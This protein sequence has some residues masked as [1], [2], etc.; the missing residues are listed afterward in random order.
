MTIAYSKKTLGAG[1]IGG[2]GFWL[3]KD[4]LYSINDPVLAQEI[5]GDIG[6][7][8]YLVDQRVLADACVFNAQTPYVGSLY[9]R[10]EFVIDDMDYPAIVTASDTLAAFTGTD[11][12]LF[13][14]IEYV[15]AQILYGRYSPVGLVPYQRHAGNTLLNNI[16]GTS[17][18]DAAT[19]IPIGS[20]G[21]TDTLP[22]LF[23]VSVVTGSI[24]DGDTCQVTISQYSNGFQSWSVYSEEI[25]KHNF[26]N[27]GNTDHPYLRDSDN[28]VTVDISADNHN[29]HVIPGLDLQFNVD[30]VDGSAAVVSVGYEYCNA[31]SEVGEIGD[32][33][34]RTEYYN[35][36]SAYGLVDSTGNVSSSINK[37]MLYK[38]RIYNV[39]GTLQT[40]CQFH[41]RPLVRLDQSNANT[42]F[43]QWFMGPAGDC[44][45]TKNNDDAYA[46]TFSD[47][48]AGSPN[49]ISLHCS[50][51]VDML[52]TEINS[53]TYVPTGTTH[54]DATG[55][56][57][58]GSTLYRW[59]ALGIYFVLATSTTNASTASVWVKHGDEIERRLQLDTAQSGTTY[60]MITPPYSMDV[61]GWDGVE[62]N[63]GAKYP[64]SPYAE[65]TY[66]TGGIQTQG[67]DL[68]LV[69]PNIDLTTTHWYNHNFDIATYPG[70]TN[71]PYAGLSE[72]CVMVTCDDPRY[73]Q[74]I[75]MTFIATADRLGAEDNTQNFKGVANI[76]IENDSIEFK[77][78]AVVM[79]VESKL[80]LR[81]NQIPQGLETL[82]ADHG[83]FIE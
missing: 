63:G 78:A 51:T 21:Y 22:G 59:D 43:D 17:L 2:N 58:D 42:P 72:Y 55:L 83:V 81:V 16:T 35:P 34:G 1:S 45:L 6:Y 66:I 64:V 29:L 8:T 62:G 65:E 9:G 24:V 52:I 26:F 7:N 70:L 53:M 46:L 56:K 69:V 48:A 67:H 33:L 73:F 37:G 20:S 75:P 44:S 10:L 82:M 12:Y 38:W 40:G 14:A 76:A 80:V 39:S 25:T 32:I 57:C 41:V 50:A 79:D 27:Y 47:L 18:M 77:G 15:G 19:R 13:K 60:D 61:G 5:F 54:A 3:V 71:Y 23:L 4:S 30:L 74:V 68:N 49:T 31:Y 11:P 28:P 36:L